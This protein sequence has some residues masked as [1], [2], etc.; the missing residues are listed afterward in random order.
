[1]KNY[2]LQETKNPDLFR[3]VD[4]SGNWKNYYHKPSNRFLKGVTTILDA[5]YAKGARFNSYLL[6]V[7]KEEATKLLET[8]GNRGDKIHQAIAKLFELGGKAER[9]KFYVAD[10]ETKL[11]VL[12]SPDEWSALLAFAKFWNDHEAVL[13]A[14]EQPVFSLQ[15][16]YAGTFDGIVILKKACGGRSCKCKDFLDKAGVWDWKS[17]GA[18]YDSYGPQVAAY[19]NAE[20]TYELLKDIP[21]YTAILRVG[22]KHVSGYETDLYDVKETKQHWKEFLSAKL[23]A[24]VT[25][26]DFTPEEVK[27]IPDSIE[28]KIEVPKPVEVKVKKV[29]RKLTKVK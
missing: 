20:N 1:M 22:T 7:T 17:G 16:G 13:V 27:E 28:L 11:Q 4:Q 24:D 2:T 10:P 19:A 25:C 14:Q 26:P 18:I 5:G 23:I 12:L 9:E 29:V 21:K 3:V 8:A 6:S 15:Y